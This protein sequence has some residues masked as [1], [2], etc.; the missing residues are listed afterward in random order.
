MIETRGIDD[1]GRVVI[2]KI[3]RRQLDISTGDRLEIEIIDNQITI[4]PQVKNGRCAITGKT[5][6]VELYCGAIPLSPE[7]KKILEREINGS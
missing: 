7:G 2:P 5:E 3:Y 1:L 4:R 6:G